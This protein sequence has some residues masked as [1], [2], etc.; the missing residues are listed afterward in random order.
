MKKQ[1]N[2]HAKEIIQS[3]I[4]SGCEVRVDKKLNKLFKIN[5]K[6]Q[7]KKIGKQNT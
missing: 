2:S 4:N 7:K 3:L 1:L 6:K 5:L